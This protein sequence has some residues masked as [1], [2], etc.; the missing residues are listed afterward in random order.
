MG[1]AKYTFLSQEAI[2]IQALLKFIMQQNRNR[3]TIW[4]E[5][6]VLW[7]NKTKWRK[8]VVSVNLTWRISIPS[9]IGKYS[10]R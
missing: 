8:F 7:E 4:S 6:F 1:V 9:S 5:M 2:G 3:S 10:Q